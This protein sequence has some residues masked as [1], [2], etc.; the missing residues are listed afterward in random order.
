M[1]GR[2]Q[3]CASC[4]AGF[5]L[6][7]GEMG[8]DLC[9]DDLQTIHS[10]EC[11]KRTSRCTDCHELVRS[12]EL[13]AHREVRCSGR[14][15]RCSWCFA[16]FDVAGSVAHHESCATRRMWEGLFASDEGS[17]SFEPGTPR[18][19][20]EGGGAHDAAAP[21]QTGTIGASAPD[22]LALARVGEQLRDDDATAR[23]S[24]LELL[25]TCDAAQRGP[26]MTRVVELVRDKNSDVRGLAVT[27]L[28]ACDAEEREPHRGRIVELVRDEEWG[29]TI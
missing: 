24:A 19:E 22:A 10:S 15:L 12:I 20:L 9:V 18:D 8:D 13:D 26:H 3:S 27:L 17:E 23:T 7:L 16:R 6:F 11:I 28:K 2:Y 14:L 21:H 29:I 5:S 1:G 4:L 25:T